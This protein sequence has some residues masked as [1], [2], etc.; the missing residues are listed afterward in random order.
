[1]TSLLGARGGIV[2][3]RGGG[4]NRET[5]GTPTA[6]QRRA[7]G[8][9]PPCPGRGQMATA[10]GAHGGLTPPARRWLSNE[11]P[12]AFGYNGR[13]PRDARMRLLFAIPHYFNAAPK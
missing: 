8:V 6:N 1:M 12:R 11:S 5:P 13:R 9:S 7:G 2:G 3:R 4:R 10:F